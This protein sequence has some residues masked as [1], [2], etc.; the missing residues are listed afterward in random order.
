LNEIYKHDKAFYNNKNFSGAVS[1][2]LI[3]VL[4][5]IPN[6]DDPSDNSCSIYLKNFTTEKTFSNHKSRCSGK[7]IFSCSTCRGGFITHIDMVDH[8]LKKHKVDSSFKTTGLFVGKSRKQK[9]KSGKQ[10][11]VNSKAGFIYEKTHVPLMAGLTHTS[12]VVNPKLKTEMNLFLK[13]IIIMSDLLRMHLVLDCVVSKVE[14]D[15]EKQIRWTTRSSSE[16][17]TKNSDIDRTIEKS[18]INI[19][20]NLDLLQSMPS[21]EYFIIFSYLF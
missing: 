3:S 12:Q 20:R 11:T 13:K 18:R 10:Q 16:I 17:V 1:G 5:I 2:C 7:Q 9:S 4:N 8:V 14:G 21:G 6:L 19:Q 15:T